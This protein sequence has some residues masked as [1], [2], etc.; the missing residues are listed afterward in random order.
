VAGRP[1]PATATGYAPPPGLLAEARS[2]PDPGADKT[3]GARR[4]RDLIATAAA[5]GDRE[6]L[7]VDVRGELPAGVD[8]AR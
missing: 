2:W 8:P 6:P 7:R 3:G 5:G 4:Q 1:A